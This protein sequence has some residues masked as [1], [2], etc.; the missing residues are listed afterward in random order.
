MSQSA[1]G[2][3]AA[4]QEYFNRSTRSL[5]EP[6]SGYAPSEGM[7]T[8]TQQVAHVA[9]TVEWFIEGA[10]RAEGFGRI[11]AL[12]NAPIWPSSH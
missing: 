4:A 5:T 1:V 11:L 2:Q 8:A 6:L 7:F 3:I 12:F 9:Q 10:F